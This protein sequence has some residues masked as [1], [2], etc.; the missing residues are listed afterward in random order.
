L[1]AAAL[2][3]RAAFAQGV[4]LDR[5]EPANAG[6][7]FFG[8]DSPST[9]GDDPT[10][11]LMLLG[12]YAQNPFVLHHGPGV[13]E[14]EAQISHQFFLHINGS[15]VVANR[16][17]LNFDVP[18]LAS[19]AGALSQDGKARFGDPRVG[20]RVKLYGGQNDAFQAAVGGYLFFPV[21]D[22]SVWVT[23]EKLRGMPEL[24]L[25]GVA[26]RFVWSAN[27]AFMFRPSTTINIASTQT[28][29]L[30][31]SQFRPSIGFG[32]LLGEDKATQIGPEMSAS[33][34]LEDANKQNTNI[35]LLFGGRH[36]FA[37]DFEFGMAVG[38]GLARGL[39]TP[40]I[41]A[42]GSL[43]YT[44]SGKPVIHDKDG[45][46][47]PD[48]LDQ[49][50]SVAAPREAN[51]D[52]PGC[53]K[54]PDRDNDGIADAKDACPDVAGVLDRNGCPPDTDGDGIADP[55]D[56]CPSVAG[57]VSQDKAKNGCPAPKD[58]D[59]DGIFDPEDACPN[60]KGVVSANKLENGCPPDSD[61]DGIRDDQDA[62]P[63]EKGVADKDPT[64]N[65]CP[66]SVRLVGDEV[67][68][69]EQV[70]FE[71]ASAKIKT[72][73]KELLDQV[74]Q[75]LKD[76]PELKKLEVQG[77]TDSKGAKFINKKLSQD[78]AESVKKALGERGIDESRLTAKG[79]GSE[80]PVADNKTDE[81]RSKNRR[82]QFV[83]LEKAKP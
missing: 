23:D 3:P 56:A 76:H 51:A 71:T 12:D 49:C 61:G 27:A 60:I 70:Q 63:K 58:S 74:A 35:E 66:K 50:P 69:L 10:P 24:T 25:G 67:L 78:R 62:C 54:D 79:Y 21:G 15:V 8:V 44:P 72:E 30:Q 36:R 43:A 11:H 9:V 55:D 16:V 5:F 2:L 77:H 81:G 13:T 19:E 4:A 39:G 68:I 40:E 20:L 42:V 32:F 59:G 83:V 52:R 33:F 45:D 14:N 7:R 34:V 47:T 73:S 41:R 57:I 65:G 28:S 6:D 1:S 75:V 53:P 37:E 82:V 48:E 29:I 26:N 80:K 64:K 31:G 17:N 18:Y 46:G 38:P 22:S